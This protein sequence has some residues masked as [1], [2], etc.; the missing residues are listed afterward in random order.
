MLTIIGIVNEPR[1][2]KEKAQLDFTIFTNF[3]NPWA[4]KGGLLTHWNP[5]FSIYRLDILDVASICP[6]KGR[7]CKWAR[8]DQGKWLNWTSQSSQIFRI[9]EQWRGSL[10]HWS[11][12]VSIY[13]LDISDIANV[14]P[15]KSRY[16]KWVTSYQGKWLGWTSQ[17]S[18]KFTILEH[19][20]GVC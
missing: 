3:H 18:Q 15:N 16:C 10:T 1:P 7:Y 12:H 4:L 9:L 8:S 14:G 6:N 5:Q 2:T 20:K 17:S 13:R 19:L 11:P